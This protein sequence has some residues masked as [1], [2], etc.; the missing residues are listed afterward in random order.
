[1]SRRLRTFWSLLICGS[2]LSTGCQPVQPFF[3]MEDGDLSHYQGMATEIDYPDVEEPCLCETSCAT[4]PLT[5]RNPDNCEIWSITLQEV[6][7]ITLNNSKVMRQL[8]GR[9]ASTAPETISRTITSPVA[10]ATVYDPALTES[11]TGTSVTSAFGGTGVEAAL[12]EFDAQLDASVFWNKNRTPQNRDTS[13]FGED[14]S[15]AILAQD[16]GTFTSGITKV[17]APGTQFS[18]RNNTR[19]EGNNISSGNAI[20]AFQAFPSAWTT[21]FEASFSHPFFQGSGTKYNRIAGP[22][23]FNQYASGAVNPIDGVMIARIRTDLSLADFEGGVRNLMCDVE[24]VYWDLYFAYRDLQARKLGRDSS[25]ET[26]KNVHAKFLTGSR[27]GSADREAQARSQYF[28]FRSQVEQAQTELF[29]TE[30]R[31]RYIMGLPPS[32]GKLIRP[33]DDPTTASI[34][35]DWAEVHTEALVRRVEIRKQK[36]EVKRRELGLIAARNHLLPRL[37]AV[38]T[39]RWLGLGNELIGQNGSVPFTSPG[40]N[41]FDILT[42]GDFQEWQLGLQLSVP[43]GYRQQVSTVRHNELLLARERAVLNNLELEICHQI[44]DAIRDHDLNYGQTQT[45]FNRALAAEREVQTVHEIYDAGRTTLDQLLDAQRRRAEAESSYYQALVDY[46]KAISL[47][48]CRKGSALDYNGVYLSEGPWPGKAYFDAMRR[49]RQRDASMY[50]DYGFTM[51][52][53]VSRGPYQNSRANCYNAEETPEFNEAPELIQGEIS[54]DE[55]PEPTKADTI[56]FIPFPDELSPLGSSQD[57]LLNK[58]G[59]DP[60]E[61]DST[62]EITSEQIAEI[63]NHLRS[64]ATG[65]SSEFGPSDQ[66]QPYHPLILQNPASKPTTPADF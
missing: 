22:F 54:T 20:N 56:Q 8:G 62:L 45:L 36:W 41:A 42:G 28:L 43:I 26:W 47:V 31:L 12:S 29:R 18:I 52:G 11:T 46:N 1:M 4:P 10:V 6:T 35:F 39:Y 58:V 38:G 44:A 48:H 40:S 53:I 5:L 17:T 27:D 21:N 66:W 37:D 30:S 60:S 14:F 7:R 33:S 57:K 65:E 23:S 2:V 15:P 63:G 24:N 59:S 50:L 51:P 3:F 32:D 64:N 9:V 19:Y 34:H 16:L 61:I 55:L 49:A 25:L 13:S